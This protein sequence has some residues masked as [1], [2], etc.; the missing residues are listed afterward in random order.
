VTTLDDF[1]LDLTPF[2]IPLSEAETSLT[3]HEGAAMWKLAGLPASTL[4]DDQLTGIC[5]IAMMLLRRR[6][7]GV[8]WQ[9]VGNVPRGKLRAL[10]ADEP[11]LTDQEMES[12]GQGDEPGVKDDA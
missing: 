7:P 5:V 12:L 4:L 1:E 8:T 6:Q 2:D 11:E 10:F 3:G 9:I